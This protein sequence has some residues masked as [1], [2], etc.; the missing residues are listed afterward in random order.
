MEKN[1]DKKKQIFDMMKKI[2]ETCGR[3][4][5]EQ[6]EVDGIRESLANKSRDSPGSQGLHNDITWRDK[7]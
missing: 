6:R 3:Y 1:S 2:Y 5:C 7:A 4:I